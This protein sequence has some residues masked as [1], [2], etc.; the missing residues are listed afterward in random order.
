[1]H[2]RLTYVAIRPG[3]MADVQRIYR[4]QVV[5]AAEI[6]DGFRGAML[7]VEDGGEFAVSIT[8]WDS[9]D[10]ATAAEANGY[11]QEQLAKFV[12]VLVGAPSRELYDVAVNC[13]AGAVERSHC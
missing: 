1:M 3:K 8:Y 7:L 10:S 13:S 2:A 11:Y 4:D 6:Q 12:D 9:H 5:P